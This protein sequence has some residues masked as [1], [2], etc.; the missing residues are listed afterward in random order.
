M[1]PAQLNYE[2]GRR[3]EVRMRNRTQCRG[4]IWAVVLTMF[5]AIAAQ[6]QQRAGTLIGSVVDERGVGLAGVTITLH[7]LDAT[8]WRTTDVNGQFR[9]ANVAPG[10]YQI[11]AAL[12]AFTTV[13]YSNVEIQVGREARLL[14]PLRTAASAAMGAPPPPEAPIVETAG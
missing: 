8:E 2:I 12:E 4:C 5:G 7:G 3:D 9:L 10:S 1:S 13:E 6:A 11:T 14:I